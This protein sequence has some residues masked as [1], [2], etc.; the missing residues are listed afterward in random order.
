M[1]ASELCIQTGKIN[2]SQYL[3]T[4]P[5]RSVC[6]SSMKK[7]QLSGFQLNPVKMS[8]LVPEALFAP[9]LTCSAAQRGAVASTFWSFQSSTQPSFSFPED[10][11]D[12]PW[13]MLRSYLVQNLVHKASQRSV[14]S[15]IS[16]ILILKAP[17][18]RA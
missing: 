14:L 13:C 10:A 7:M 9:C 1:S 4:P 17:T 6:T 3:S 2:L 15:N 8:L 5:R 11:P 16:T 18:L 12:L